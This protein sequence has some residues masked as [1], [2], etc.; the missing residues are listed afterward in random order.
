[1]SAVFTQFNPT[2]IQMVI[3]SSRVTIWGSL[4][5][6]WPIIVGCYVNNVIQSLQA[7]VVGATMEGQ[8]NSADGAFTWQ[9]QLSGTGVSWQLVATPT[10]GVANLQAGT[11]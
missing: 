3:G 9:F 6:P 1:M 10:G 4:P 11:F 8:F 7:T 2:I 5:V